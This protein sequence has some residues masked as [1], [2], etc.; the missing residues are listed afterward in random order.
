MP[1]MQKEDVD[2]IVLSESV[3]IFA[4]A[5]LELSPYMPSPYTFW[6]C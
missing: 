6:F 4:E 1:L 2:P 3:L 5:V